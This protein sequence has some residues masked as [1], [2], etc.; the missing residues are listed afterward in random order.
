MPIPP[1]QVLYSD[2]KEFKYLYPNRNWSS[3]IWFIIRLTSLLYGK[4]QEFLRYVAL[5]KAAVV[6]D[7]H[8]TFRYGLPKSP[9]IDIKG[10]LDTYLSDHRSDLHLLD[11]W[12][13]L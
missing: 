8:N 4:L 10:R 11:F 6:Q 7:R 9:T 12:L 1:E 13:N 3:N 2:I 5:F